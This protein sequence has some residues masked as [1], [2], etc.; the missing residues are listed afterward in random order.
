MR[1]TCSHISLLSVVVPVCVIGV[2]GGSHVEVGDDK[3]THM[4]VEENSVKVLPFPPPEKLFVVKQE[5]G[6]ALLLQRLTLLLESRECLKAFPFL[7]NS[8]EAIPSVLGG[9]FCDHWHE[10]VNCIKSIHV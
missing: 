4:V 3:C 10:I 6:E 7:L 9:F 2:S 1:R 8:R 5:V